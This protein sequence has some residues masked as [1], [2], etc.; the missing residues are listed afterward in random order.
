[1]AEDRELL[2]QLEKALRAG[3]VEPSHARV[4]AV[5]RLVA[6][7]RPSLRAVSSSYNPSSAAGAANVPPPPRPPTATAPPSPR[8]AWA[9]RRLTMAF[10]GVAAAALLV[11]ATVAAL[12]SVPGSSAN[13]SS[14]LLRAQSA[15]YRVQVALDHKDPGQVAKADADLLRTAESVGGDERAE[16]QRI[17]VPVHVQAI[18][19]LRDHASPEV[20]S[21]VPGA[22][23][24]GASPNS[25]ASSDVS[26]PSLTS[27]PT[28]TVPGVLPTSIPVTLPRVIG[29]PTT[30]APVGP[31]AVVPSVKISG[32]NPKLDGSFEV[33]FVV[34]GFTPDA[35]G[36]PG[37]FAVRFSYDNGAE[38]TTYAGDSPWSLPLLKAIL[39]RQLCVEVVDAT[40]APLPG[41]GNCT[42]IINL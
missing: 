25:A 1:M 35:G 11:L 10:S 37:T 23:P 38:P 18:A 4:Q 13:H 17:A 7:H 39:H 19:F 12:Q 30:T 3:A 2:D 15:A 5:R 29:A 20:L 42:N 33:N 8:W 28:V 36:A 16:A 9:D 34:S 22:R 27:L 21:D 6:R 41:S 26:V 14:A 32:I 24:A 40:G 31:A